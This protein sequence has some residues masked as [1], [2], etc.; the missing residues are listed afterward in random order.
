[1]NAIFIKNVPK[2]HSLERLTT[3]ASTSEHKIEIFR[4]EYLGMLLRSIGYELFLRIGK[5]VRFGLHLQT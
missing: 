1:M 4:I 2:Q 3:I 5:S